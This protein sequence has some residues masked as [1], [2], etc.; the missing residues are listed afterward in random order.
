MIDLGEN[1]GQDT[2]GSLRRLPFA[3]SFASNTLLSVATSADFA[4]WRLP[5]RKQLSPDRSRPS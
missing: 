3:R 4:T 2:Q 1:R 5:W